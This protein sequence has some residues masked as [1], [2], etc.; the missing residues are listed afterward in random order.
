[1]SKSTAPFFSILLPTR[2]HADLLELS[3]GSVLSQTFDDFEVIVSDNN[4][5]DGTAQLLQRMA[6]SDSRVKIYR[7][8]RDLPMGENWNFCYSK[9]SGEF[10]ILLGDDD[11]LLPDI[12]QKVHE[13]AVARPEADIIGFRYALYQFASRLLLWHEPAGEPVI[14]GSKEMFLQ[15]AFGFVTPVEHTLAVRLSLA[16]AAFPKGNPYHGAYLDQPAWFGF[17]SRA[18]EIRYIE[19][20]GVILG[21]SAGSSTTMQKNYKTRHESF[22][23][24]FS[25]GVSLPFHGDYFANM[26]YETLALARQAY[27][28]FCTLPISMQKYWAKIGS[29]IDLLLLQAL[30]HLDWAELK[31][32]LADF[33]H[34]ILHAPLRAKFA[35]FFLFCWGLLSSALPLYFREGT[36]DLVLKALR[37]RRSYRFRFVRLGSASGS[38]YSVQEA[39]ARIR[40]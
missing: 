33:W 17:Y 21:I 32:L 29:E 31:P 8:T 23:G 14:E 1:M 2:N 4:S 39:V 10:F 7:Q 15:R 20:A 26:Q 36:K 22:K 37:L 11:A 18:R 13:V 3:L 25:N 5:S 34:F 19:S 6:A 12:L 38:L 16:R 30:V 28:A 27:P 40:A 24:A 9:A 35:S